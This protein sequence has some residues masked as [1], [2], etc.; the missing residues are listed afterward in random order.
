MRTGTD[1]RW[2]TVMKSLLVTLGFLFFC[3]TASGQLPHVVSHQGYLEVAGEPLTDH[4]AHL[5]FRI[6][7]VPDLGEP[8]WAEEHTG[9]DIIDGMFSVL[10][11]ISSPVGDLPFGVPLWLGTAVGEGA[12][13]SPRTPLGAVPYSLQSRSL[14]LPFVGI[15]E[16]DPDNAIFTLHNVGAADGIDVIIGDPQSESWDP[17]NSTADG[18]HVGFSPGNGVA[19]GFAGLNGVAVEKGVENGVLVNEA[20]QHGMRVQTAGGAGVRVESVGTNGMYVGEA[21]HNGLFVGQAGTPTETAGSPSHDGIEVTGAQGNGVFVGRADL[22][23]THILSAGSSGLRIDD[24]ATNGI[25]VGASGENGLFV[26]TAGSPGETFGSASK[27]GLEV[28]GAQGNGVFIGR[29]NTGVMIDS[30]SF[31]GIHIGATLFGLQIERTQNDGI[32]VRQ[33]GSLQSRTDPHRRNGVEI[34]GVDDNG[35]YVGRA[36]KSGAYFHHIDDDGIFIGRVGDP[37]VYG[38]YSALKNGLELGSAQGHGLFVGYAG[39]A[40]LRVE[41]AINNGV[42]VDSTS[43]N[44]MHV[45]VAEQDGF[46]VSEAGGYGLYVGHAGANGVHVSSAD[47]W[48][49]YFDGNVRV[50]GT[51]DNTSDRRLK[52]AIRPTPYGLREILQLRPVEYHWKDRPADGVGIGLIAQD[53]ESVIP[54]IVSRPRERDEAYGLSYAELIPIL[55]RAVQEQ[56]AEIEALRA[57]LKDLI[58]AGTR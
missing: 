39:A 57:D 23:G 10:L 13:L 49:G 29:S 38:K 19:V 45:N 12:E 21:G 50:T 16:S 54:E 32:Y 9:V 5:I 56:Q 51:L 36:G 7:E 33:V 27:D 47:G 15:A 17:N 25:Y 34:G 28:Q 53:V 55:I 46:A 30:S 44:G 41:K 40:G 18:I 8:I 6:Y 35:L 14:Q 1:E 31:A 4:S 52:E 11:G 3:S 2:C 42:Y 22:H 20:V 48:A 24:A 58:S 26:G 43:S 37:G